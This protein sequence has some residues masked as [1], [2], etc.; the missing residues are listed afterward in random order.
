MPQFK[1]ITY[2]KMLKETLRAYH[3]VNTSG[4]LSY[5]YKF[6]LCCLY[7]LQIPFNNFDTWRIRKQLIASCLWQIGQ[8]TN[9]LNYL[10]DSTLSRIVINQSVPVY[11]FAPEIDGL[12]STLFAPEIDGLES[13]IYAPNIDDG[14]INSS[15]VTIHVPNSIFTNSATMS[16]LV[17]EIE[18]IKIQGIQYQIVSL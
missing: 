12:E 7:V 8:L 10:Y 4:R 3:S 9:V 14:I 13:L 2:Y 5:M 11:I 16:L 18:Q 17:S 1:T 6:C 15:I